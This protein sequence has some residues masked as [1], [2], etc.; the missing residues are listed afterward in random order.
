[1]KLILLSALLLAPAQAPE[2]VFL[3]ELTWTEV[4][5]LLAAGKTT[6][7]VA[8]AGNEQNGPHMVLGKHEYIMRHTAERIARELGN[9]LVAPIVT[10]V[11]EGAID[12]ASGHM[13]YPG[14]ISL[15]NVY[16][17]KIYEYAARSLKAHGFT[18]IVFLGD[19]GGNQEGMKEVALALNAE[20]G[21]G[22]T[23]VHFVP[24]YYSE[25]G[26]PEWLKSQGETEESIGRHAGISDTSQLLAVAP[27]Y[28]RKDKLAPKGGFERSGVSGDPTKASVEYGK[29]GI[30]LKV[31]T[32]VARIRKLV[33][34]R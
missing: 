21:G 33:S 22:K 12:P 20:W 26:Y 32:A 28:V 11:P 9:A 23:R 25:N 13:R 19:S 15:P 2:T 7:I 14:T 18:D 1:M 31:E 17:M 6:V 8:S 27:Q 3:E 4:R 24:E 10:Y 30:E 16:F 29:K 34:E 5:D